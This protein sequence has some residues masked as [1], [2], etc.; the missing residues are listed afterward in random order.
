MRDFWACGLVCNMWD[1]RDAYHAASPQAASKMDVASN[2]ASKQRQVKS[3]KISLK[4][5]EEKQVWQMQFIV[6]YNHS[7]AWD[8]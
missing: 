7:P 8:L 2:L 4:K 1:I 3:R 6:T 5:F